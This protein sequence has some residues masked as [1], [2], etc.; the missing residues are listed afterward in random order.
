MVMVSPVPM[1]LILINQV[2]AILFVLFYL[3]NISAELTHCEEITEKLIPEELNLK[4]P[5]RGEEKG[6]NI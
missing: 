5:S 1:G 2:I 6:L 4:I 3:K